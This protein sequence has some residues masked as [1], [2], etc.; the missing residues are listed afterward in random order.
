MDTVY[1]VL[2]KQAIKLFIDFQK[3]LSIGHFKILRK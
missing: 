3:T 1:A 2:S